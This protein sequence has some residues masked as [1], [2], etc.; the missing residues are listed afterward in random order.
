MADYIQGAPDI[1][2]EVIS[3]SD[4][5]SHLQK[6]VGEYLDAGSHAVWVVYPD[7]REVHVFGPTGA[8]RVLKGAD[9]LEIPDLLPGL[10]IPLA[11]IF[12]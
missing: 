4:S 9:T 2:V 5:A 12:D 1:A 8:V 11:A 7:T 10:S 3:P 6:K